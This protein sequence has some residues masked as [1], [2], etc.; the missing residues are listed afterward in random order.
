M[1][2]CKPQRK[3]KNTRENLNKDIV[4]LENDILNIEN[5]IVEFAKNY[6]NERVKKSIVELRSDLKYL[7][8]LTNGV[9]IDQNEHR[10]I[11]DFLRVHYNYLQE[12]LAFSNKLS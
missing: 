3:V 10:E 5:K 1:W 11:M 12:K 9:E 6:Q 4:N 8:V 2:I 7:A